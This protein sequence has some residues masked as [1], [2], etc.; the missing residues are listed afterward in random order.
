ML[1][2]SA[3]TPAQLAAAEQSTAGVDYVGIGAVHETTSK[4]DAPPPLGVAGVVELARSC[5]LPTVAIGGIGPADLP[6]LRTGGLTGAAVVSWICAASDPRRA[7]AELA[8]AWAT[9]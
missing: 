9:P 7:A 8:R 5:A 6:A 1:G 4:A 3:R 2:L